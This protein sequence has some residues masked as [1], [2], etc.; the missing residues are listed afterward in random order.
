MKEEANCPRM[1]CGRPSYL[2]DAKDGV[3]TCWFCGE[4]WKPA[5]E[6]ELDWAVAE[7]NKFRR[8]LG[9]PDVSREDYEIL[10][11]GDGS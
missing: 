10:E 11:D 7:V 6:D 1:G 3:L 2:S 4:E 9:L 8:R 5:L